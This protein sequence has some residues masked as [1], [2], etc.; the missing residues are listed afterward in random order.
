MKS[1]SD[2]LH[3]ILKSHV[4]PDDK[5]TKRHKTLVELRMRQMFSTGTL[6]GTN[7]PRLPRV[8]SKLRN[9]PWRS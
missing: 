6:Q 2:W 8:S 3:A 1:V 5:V 7:V 9:A 4:L